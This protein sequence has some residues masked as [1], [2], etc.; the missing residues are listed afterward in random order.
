MQWGGGGR[1]GEEKPIIHTQSGVYSLL[2]LYRSRVDRA[3]FAVNL[4]SQN[5]SRLVTDKLKM[6]PQPLRSTASR[7]SLR[8][9]C[10]WEVT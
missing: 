3:G 7:V 1:E 10:T 9:D 2:T 5:G 4:K 8:R 6:F